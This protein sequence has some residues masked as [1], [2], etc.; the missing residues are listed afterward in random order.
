MSKLF[1]KPQIAFVR[2]SLGERRKLVQRD[3]VL[4]SW[5]GGPAE[6]VGLGGSEFHLPSELPFTGSSFY[7]QAL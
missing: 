6:K 3:P 5:P 1:N 2:L 7:T 4:A